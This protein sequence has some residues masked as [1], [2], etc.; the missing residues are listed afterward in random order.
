MC[1]ARRSG[2]KVDN[3]AVATQQFVNL[4]R[5]GLTHFA[6]ALSANASTAV[7]RD[8]MSATIPRMR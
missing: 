6:Q 2:S 3:S 5:S 8:R 7:L 4:R 1:F